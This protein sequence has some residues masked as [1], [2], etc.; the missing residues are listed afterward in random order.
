MFLQVSRKDFIS[1]DLK[2]FIA[3]SGDDAGVAGEAD[4]E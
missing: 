1:S 3:S 2:S 4:Q